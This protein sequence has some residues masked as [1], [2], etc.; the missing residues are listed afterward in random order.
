VSLSQL[1]RDL[2]RRT[3]RPV[4]LDAV[5]VVEVR[6][7]WRWRVAAVGGIAIAASINGALVARWWPERLNQAIVAVLI[8]LAALVIAAGMHSRYHN[9][10]PLAAFRADQRKH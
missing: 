9:R 5:R 2:V 10:P 4:V 7:P 8:A 3:A 1:Q 6:N